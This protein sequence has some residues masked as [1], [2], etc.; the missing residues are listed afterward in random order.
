MIVF[1][2]IG[3]CGIPTLGVFLKNQNQ[4]SVSVITTG[5]DFF[6]G[7][8]ISVAVL[9]IQAFALARNADWEL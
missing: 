9:T 3:T 8:C 4:F 1:M 5:L 7:C 6:V 2:S